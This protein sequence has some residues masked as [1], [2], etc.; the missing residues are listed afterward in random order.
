[1]KK[2]LM[3]GVAAI[4]LCAAF[5]SCSKNEE[6]YN[7]EQIDQMKAEEIYNAYSDAFVEYIGGSVASNQDW[8]FGSAKT[9][10]E[11][12]NANL[13]YR[14]YEVPANVTDYERTKVTEY[15]TNHL[16][17][18]QRRINN[19]DFKDFF[20]YQVYKGEESYN[21]A[22]GNSA[23]VGSDHVNHLQ[24]YVGGTMDEFDASTEQLITYNSG[25]YQL[26]TKGNLKREHMNN[27]NKGD[28]QNVAYQDGHSG[29]PN[30]AIIGAMLM[31]NSGTA[32]F[33]FHGTEDNKYHNTY[34]IIPG[35][36][37]DPSLAGFW[38]VGF[39]FVATGGYTDEGGNLQQGNMR[40]ERDWQFNDWIVRISPAQ[41]IGT[42]N[43]TLRVLGE[44][45][46][47]SST[48]TG[49]DKDADFDFN[50][51][52]FDVAF[53]NSGTDA[54][55][56]TWIRLMAAGGTLP[57]YIGEV[58]DENEVHKRFGDY[59]V[60]TMINT[61]WPSGANNVP[62]VEWRYSD[63]I[64]NAKNIPVTVMKNG[65]PLVLKAE[66]GEPASKI[67]VND[68]HFRWCDERVSMKQHF[69]LFLDWCTANSFTSTWW[70]QVN[71]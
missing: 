31:V 66:R 1:M 19:V 59:P 43:Y 69:P 29:D 41:K 55:K 49:V 37:I 36:E 38:Y 52:V 45:L 14:D 11:Y 54:E 60:T 16:F 13:W 50:D 63:Q 5:T 62:S 70:L 51:V 39:D 24:T 21:N 4:A 25:N 26:D 67:A 28:N 17:E 10:G 65:S 58:T 8:G 56:G 57:L 48:A 27:F 33:S 20:I 7:P 18:N 68:V 6:L 2:Y 3:T 22:Y 46:T 32:D 40:I 35:E 12:A 42:R 53:V 15:F 44:D 64:V 23:G 71:P 30:Y 34:V 9:R 47:F 61:N